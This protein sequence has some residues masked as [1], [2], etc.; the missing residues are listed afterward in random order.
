[1]IYQF[2]LDD[3]DYEADVTVTAGRD[4][5]G[6]TMDG[7]GDPPEGAE[8]EINHIWLLIKGK[9]ELELPHDF[10]DYAN[11]EKHLLNHGSDILEQAGNEAEDAKADAAEARADAR[12]EDF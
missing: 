12:K 5:T 7:P 8:I 3:V 11:V 2:S 6:P 10:E 9:R 4:A 1:M